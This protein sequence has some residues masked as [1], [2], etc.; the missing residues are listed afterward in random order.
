MRT[1]TSSGAGQR[2]YQ[3]GR[4]LKQEDAPLRELRTTED[5][6][7]TLTASS[8]TKHRLEILR[9]TSP[10]DESGGKINAFQIDDF[11]SDNDDALVANIK[12]D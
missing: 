5:S 12:V 9:F 10:F 2:T 4:Y 11:L 3:R 6:L 7:I 8:K 1:L